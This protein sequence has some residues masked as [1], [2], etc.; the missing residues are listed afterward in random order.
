MGLTPQLT[1]ALFC[2][3]A[4][5]G[6]LVHGCNRSL[7]EIIQ[8]LNTL[9]EKKNTTEKELLCR[10]T[11]V[12]RQMYNPQS[13]VTQCLTGHKDRDVLSRLKQLYRI[14]HSMVQSK[15]CPVNESMQTT[16]K[17][18]LESLKR[19]MQKKYSQCGSLL[20]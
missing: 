14:L 2:L 4:C 20:S 19:I 10:A 18:F 7:T 1:A 11:A 15:N 5:T 13:K 3:L 6:N 16:L 8:T 12:L 17:N 9:S